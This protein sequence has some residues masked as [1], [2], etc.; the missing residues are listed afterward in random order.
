[1]RNWAEI[2]LIISLVS[3]A[4]T[5]LGI[6]PKPL[7]YASLAVAGFLALH[8]VYEFGKS[9][10]RKEPFR[11]LEIEGGKGQVVVQVRESG[12]LDLKRKPWEGFTKAEMAQIRSA[13]TTMAV[14]HGHADVDGLFDA[15]RRGE[16]LNGPCWLC[17]RPRFQSTQKSEGDLE[18]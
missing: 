8:L 4:I 2:G 16:P 12:G 18:K 5:G 13:M 6:L 11:N 7:A 14:Y 10:G 9:R 3:L 15:Q 1:M 17:G